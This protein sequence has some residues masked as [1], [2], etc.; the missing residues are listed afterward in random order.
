M[1]PQQPGAEIKRLHFI[2]GPFVAAA[3]VSAKIGGAGGIQFVSVPCGANVFAAEINFLIANQGRYI[4]IQ[5]HRKDILAHK[6]HTKVA[7]VTISVKT[8]AV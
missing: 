2:N 8:C 4:Y 6:A 1:R 3:K 7:G 5:T